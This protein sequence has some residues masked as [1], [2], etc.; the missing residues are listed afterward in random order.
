M[1]LTIHYTLSVKKGT[2]VGQL[3][4]LLKGTRRLARRIGCD[5]V[6]RILHSTET[7]PTAPPF[8]DSAPGNERL[9]AGGPGTHGWLVEVY[10]G[11][12]CET[13]QF[14]VLRERRAI[15]S[16]K[17]KAV[18]PPRYRTRLRLD[19]FC[20]TQYAGEF[21]WEH[22]LKCHQRVIRLLDYWRENG[23]RVKVLDEG[24]YWRSRSERKLRR[25]L[26][27]Y[28]RLIAGLGGVF[29]DGCDASGGRVS[30]KAPIFSYP[31]FEQLEHEGQQQFDR[32]LLPVR[33]AIAS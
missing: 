23:A 3:K 25:I 6:G 20:K 4:D 1:G 8:F 21:G 18:W 12:G 15:P 10:P 11:K 24:G 29:K 28:D 17:R 30:V 14:G 13:A 31:N 33:R 22:F 7:D 16:K 9:L 26:G 5:C 32:W 2:T 19:W 27:E